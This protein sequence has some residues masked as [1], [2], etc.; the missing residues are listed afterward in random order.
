MQPLGDMADFIG[1]GTPCR[2]RSDFWGGDIRWASIKD[3]SSHSLISTLESI[4]PRGLA[5]STTKLITPGHVIVASRVGLGKVAINEIPV[6]INQDL[7]AIQLKPD[8]LLPRYLL[9]FLISK[10]GHLER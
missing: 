4:T 3:F 6:A 7:K 2:S 8:T 9:Y 1:G 5:N 10:A